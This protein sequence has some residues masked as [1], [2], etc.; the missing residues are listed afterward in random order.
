MT[1]NVTLQH[2][3]TSEVLVIDIEQPTAWDAKHAAERVY[4]DFRAIRVIDTINALETANAAL[5]EG[6]L[7]DF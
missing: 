7:G 2:K 1:Y 6:A 4:G 5:T 3:L